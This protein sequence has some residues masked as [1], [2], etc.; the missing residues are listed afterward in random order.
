M[1]NNTAR[2]NKYVHPFKQVLEGAQTLSNYYGYT[3]LKKGDYLPEIAHPASHI[4]FPGGRENKNQLGDITPV[5]L[6][7]LSVENRPLVILF[8]PTYHQQILPHIELLETLQKDIQVMGGSLL[9][10]SNAGIRDLGR[11]LQE[12]KALWVLSDPHNS[13]AEQF[14]LFT[15]DNPIGDWLSGIDDNIPLPAFYL[16]LPNG[17]ISYHYV[18]Y[19]FRTYQGSAD[20][21]YQ[22]GF[23]RQ[24]LTQ[25]YQNSQTL[26][27]PGKRA[28]VI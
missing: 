4:L 28:Y 15:P 5:N 14:G 2:I 7:D 26:R 24:L 13:V 17:A 16:V 12:H 27:R 18:D 21:I 19:N 10:I 8:R 9:I 20:E 25:I 1:Y 6:K 3:P 23:V 11:Q 22:Q